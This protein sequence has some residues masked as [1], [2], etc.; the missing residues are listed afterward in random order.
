MYRYSTQPQCLW[1]GPSTVFTVLKQNPNLCTGVY[2]HTY[3]SKCMSPLLLCLPKSDLY[4]TDIKRHISH[5]S[6]TRWWVTAAATAAPSTE[7]PQPAT[8]PRWTGWTGRTKNI[9][10]L[11]EGQAK[12]RHQRIDAPKDRFSGESLTTGQRQGRHSAVQHD[13]YH[14]PSGTYI[15]WRRHFFRL[16][17]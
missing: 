9:K 8:A 10:I 16:S 7:A 2:V 6:F 13:F 1:K 15:T 14:T 17:F 12:C 4:K 3:M 11:L 5:P